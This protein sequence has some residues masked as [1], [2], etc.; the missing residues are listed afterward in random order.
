MRAEIETKGAWHGFAEITQ[1]H[2]PDECV[3]LAVQIARCSDR[4]L[5]RIVTRN[6]QGQVAKRCAADLVRDG[7]QRA[8]EVEIPAMDA[9]MKRVEALKGR[10]AFAVIR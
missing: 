7:E 2:D 8:F 10:H 6:G 3:F 4:V 9:Q 1:I 5:E